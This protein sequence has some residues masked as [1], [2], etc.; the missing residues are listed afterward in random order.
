M[1][2]VSKALQCS[3][4]NGRRTHRKTDEEENGCAVNRH[5]LEHH[6]TPYAQHGTEEVPGEPSD[7]TTATNIASLPTANGCPK[8]KVVLQQQ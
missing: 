2:S 3:I 6:H 7:S 4:M 1:T 8:A 5:M